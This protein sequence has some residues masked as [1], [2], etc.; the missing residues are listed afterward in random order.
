MKTI[1]RKKPLTFGEFIAAANETW[2]HRQATKLVRFA[3]N[4]HLIKFL[5]RK[6]FSIS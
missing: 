5:G 2:G 1:T 6:H 4:A 3:V